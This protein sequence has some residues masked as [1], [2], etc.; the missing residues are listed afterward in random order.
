MTK[1]RR[2]KKVK[3]WVD[4]IFAWDP[5][6]HKAFNSSFTDLILIKL[7]P[8]TDFF[9]KGTP[10]AAPEHHAGYSYAHAHIA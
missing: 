10:E 1:K 8:Q 6:K 2:R 3:G 9:F 4:F 7:P 5:S